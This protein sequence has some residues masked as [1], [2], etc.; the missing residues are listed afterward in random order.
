MAD[1]VKDQAKDVLKCMSIASE[2]RKTPEPVRLKTLTSSQTIREAIAK[3]LP[4]APDQLLTVQVP[5]SVINPE[6]GHCYRRRNPS[7]M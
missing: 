7:L 4:V 3:A 6:Y 1:V 2:V 5:G